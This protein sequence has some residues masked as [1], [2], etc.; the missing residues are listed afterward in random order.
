MSEKQ[1]FLYNNGVP[2]EGFS[3]RCQKCGSEN[4]SVEYVFNYYG[5]LT[6]WDQSLR[7]VCRDCKHAADLAI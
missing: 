2:V 3:A 4:V 7:L 5:G 6:G 1:G